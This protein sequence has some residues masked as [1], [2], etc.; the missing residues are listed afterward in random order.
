MGSM[1]NL[2]YFLKEAFIG[3]KRHFSTAFG[4]IVTIFLSLFII[5]IFLLAGII[6][7]NVVETVEDEVGLTV[8]LADDAPD[9]D[10]QELMAYINGLDGVADTTYVSKAQALEIFKEQNAD[11]SDIIKMLEEMEAEGIN[12][13]PASIEV[14]LSDPQ[15]VERIAFDI[16]ANTTFQRICDAPADPESSI[17]YGQKTVEKL[18]TVTNYIRY[19]GI[20]L[21]ALLIFIALVF[22]NNTI[23]LAIMARQREI[24]IM[25]LVGASNGFIRGPFLTESILHAIFGAGFAIL[26]LELVRRY[27]LPIL[28]TNIEFLPLDLPMQNYYMIYGILAVAGVLIAMIGSAFAMRKYLKV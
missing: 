14:E 11:Q 16:Q 17:R 22:I 15:S 19:I 23:R 26:A 3:F 18:F 12:D 25:R 10:V 8:W 7:N 27:A 6:L 9:E 1:R 20:I 4:S 13:L 5:G 28:S 24:S 2:F 21:I